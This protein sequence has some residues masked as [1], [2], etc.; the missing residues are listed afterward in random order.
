L[1]YRGSMLRP[2][3]RPRKVTMNHIIVHDTDRIEL[4]L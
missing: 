4:P 3:S 1:L 2:E